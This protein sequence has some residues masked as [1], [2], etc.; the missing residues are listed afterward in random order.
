MKL[1][2]FGFK[3]FQ[4]YSKVWRILGVQP[5]NN[6]MI[7]PCG[8]ILAIEGRHK[9]FH[10]CFKPGLVKRTFVSDPAGVHSCHV[11]SV[12]L[13][14]QSTGTSHHV[15]GCLGHV[16]M[17]VTVAFVDSRELPLHGRYVHDEFSLKKT[18]FEEWF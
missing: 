9:P 11:D 1:P 14:L 18:L 16:G 13:E 5:M 6:R 3:V 4:K 17:W 10:L 7:N 15:Q 8:A 2:V 12:H